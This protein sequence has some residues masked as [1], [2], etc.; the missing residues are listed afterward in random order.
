MSCE[1]FYQHTAKLVHFTG[2]LKRTKSSS[3]TQLTTTNKLS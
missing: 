3:S 1:R 2:A